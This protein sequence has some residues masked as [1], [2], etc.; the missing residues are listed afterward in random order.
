MKEKRFK[1]YNANLVDQLYRWINESTKSVK[2]E[3][4]EGYDRTTIQWL[5]IISFD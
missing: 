2:I 5:V 4:I 3:K 1:V